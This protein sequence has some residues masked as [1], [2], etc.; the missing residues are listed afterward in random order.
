MTFK[1]AYTYA[2]LVFSQKFEG[3]KQL[4]DLNNTEILWVNQT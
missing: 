1:D 4:V 2:D 3:I